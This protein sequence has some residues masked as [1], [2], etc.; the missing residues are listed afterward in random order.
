LRRAAQAARADGAAVRAALLYERADALAPTALD[1]AERLVLTTGLGCSGATT[2]RRALS[3][4]RGPRP[5]TA[6]RGPRAPNA[7]P[8]CGRAAGT[9][10]ARAPRSSGAS[11]KGRGREGGAEL[12]ARLG[13]LQVTSGLFRDALATVEPL[14]D[15]A[16][17]GR[18][19]GAARTVSL[20]TASWRTR[21][22]VSRSERA[23]AWMCSS[24]PRPRARGAA[25]I[26][27]RCSPSSPAGS[28]RAGRYRAATT[29]RRATATCTRWP[30][31]RSTWARCS[32]S[33]VCTARRW[34]QRAG[35]AR[36]GTAGRG[37]GARDGAG[38][39]RQHL[40]AASAIL[41]RRGAR[42]ERAR[43]LATERK[44]TLALAAATFVEGD[45]ALRAGQARG[46]DVPGGGGGVRRRGQPIAP[47]ARFARAAEACAAAGQAEEGRRALA[48][49]DALRAPADDDAERA[50]ALA[51]LAL[52]DGGGEPAPAAPPASSAWRRRVR[53]ADRRPAGPAPGGDRRRGSPSARGDANKVTETR[54]FAR[55][56]LEEIRMAT[57]EH[58]RAGWKRDPD[59]LWRWAGRRRA[60]ATARS[61]R[62]RSPPRDGC[63]A[64]CA[65]T[66]AS[67]A[68]C[69]CRGCSR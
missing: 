12:R 65:S 57:P 61:P 2:M 37:G 58:H 68:S 1:A 51:A 42:S 59:A 4:R 41:A 26:S 33:R 54:R 55:T 16:A 39:R 46:G 13:R 52:A 25:P 53:S 31:S 7:R 19:R 34:R 6:R 36:A 30:A 17:A 66:S 64:C 69:A 8:G 22:S 62:A 28:G 9:P 24:A 10:R 49:A 45:L 47:R 20:E 50:R 21:I 35:G 18:V 38:Q 27:V 48:E 60:P 11:P 43:R 3:K 63:G 32:P 15:E 40:R 44:L 67:T 23:T 56:I 5:A 14:F 29:S